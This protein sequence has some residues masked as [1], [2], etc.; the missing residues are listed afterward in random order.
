MPTLLKLFKKTQEEG[1]LPN[2]FFEASITL[3]PKPNKD[4]TLQEKKITG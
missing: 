1:T 2:S 4:T 3:M